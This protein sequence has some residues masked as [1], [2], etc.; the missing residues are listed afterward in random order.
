MSAWSW[1]GGI[2]MSERSSCVRLQHRI[3]EQIIRRYALAQRQH[4]NTKWRWRRALVEETQT[5]MS[6]RLQAR[7]AALLRPA[8]RV[9]R[10]ALC[11]CTARFRCCPTNS[12]PKNVVNTYTESL[13]EKRAPMSFDSTGCG[14]YRVSLY[15]RTLTR[16]MYV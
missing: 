5:C 16:Y 10:L 9:Q 8:A 11:C 3:H 14:L 15:V 1:G 6:L 12:R 13:L 2:R 7:G 4:L